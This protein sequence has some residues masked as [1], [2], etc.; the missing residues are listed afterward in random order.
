LP[1]LHQ[2]GRSRKLGLSQRPVGPFLP[3][4]GLSIPAWRTGVKKALIDCQRRIGL[5]LAVAWAT[6]SGDNPC[7]HDSKLLDAIMAGGD[8]LIQEMQPDGRWVFPKKDDS[9]KPAEGR[10][11]IT[12]PFSQDMSEYVLK[13]QVGAQ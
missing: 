1:L 4:T 13:L 7:Y 3:A 12:L 10:I 11:V 2:A 5:A 9:S 6:K 8:A